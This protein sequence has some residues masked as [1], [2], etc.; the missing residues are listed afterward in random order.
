MGHETRR[1]I[2]RGNI[3]GMG[4]KIGK[5]DPDDV[6]AEEALNRGKEPMMGWSAKRPIRTQHI[7][8]RSENSIIKFITLLHVLNCPKIRA[9]ARRI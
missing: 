9:K 5:Y 7:H 3:K 2:L 8:N 4:A 1:K 6:T